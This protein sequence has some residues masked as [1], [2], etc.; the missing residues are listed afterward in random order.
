MF[1]FRIYIY[2]FVVP[3][4]LLA[5]LRI[6]SPRILSSNVVYLGCNPLLLLYFCFLVIYCDFQYRQPYSS[7]VC[8]CCVRKHETDKGPK[9]LRYVFCPNTSTAVEDCSPVSRKLFHWAERDAAGSGVWRTETSKVWRY[10]DV[11]FCILSSHF[12]C[13]VWLF[14]L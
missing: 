6:N 8:V 10:S 7:N 13:F 5:G 4:R 3:V 2:I 14:R 11:L 9:Q 1:F 12:T